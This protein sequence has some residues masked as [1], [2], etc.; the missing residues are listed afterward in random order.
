MVNTGRS[1]L[2]GTPYGHGARVSLCVVT[3]G[4]KAPSNDLTALRSKLKAVARLVREELIQSQKGQKRRYDESVQPCLF[5]PGQ[6][7]VLLLLLSLESKLLTAWKGPF[8]VVEKVGELYYFVRIP[9]K[10][11]C[12]YHINLLKRWKAR[13][14]PG[15]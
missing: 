8:E 9:G 2:P 14:D 5:V 6:Q 4:L 12:L 10:G 7:V 13:E 3:R 11:E 15:L 1:F